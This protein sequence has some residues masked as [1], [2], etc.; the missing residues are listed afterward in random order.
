MRA[1]R[2]LW[3]LVSVAAACAALAA[4]PSPAGAHVDLIA[5]EPSAGAKLDT[6]PARVLLTFTGEPVASKSS[7]RVL[8]AE[9]ARVRDVAMAEGVPSDPLQLSADVRSPLPPG[10]YTIRWKIVSSDGHTVSGSIP[11][12]VVA[13]T[14]DEDDDAAGPPSPVATPASTPSA[15]GSPG[16][17]TTAGGSGRGTLIVVVNAL[18]LAGVAVAALVLV[19]RRSRR[20]GA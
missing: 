18:L 1:S 4:A 11:F 17:A 19:R 9:G 15:A 10:R 20:R 12:R 7:I 6:S 13:A 14:Q 8:D 5:S 2:Y 16:G 3:L